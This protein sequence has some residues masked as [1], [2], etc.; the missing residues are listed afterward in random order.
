MKSEESKILL[1]KEQ[2]SELEHFSK[3]LI[4]NLSRRRKAYE[5]LTNQFEVLSLLV[6]QKAANEDIMKVAVKL[7]Q[8]SPEDINSGF[9]NECSLFT[10]YIELEKSTRI[11]ELYSYIR[12]NNLQDTVPNLEIAERIFFSY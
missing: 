4:A 2:I 5:I 7:A 6:S 9:G 11:P 1:L 12:H 8:C 3:S 10:M